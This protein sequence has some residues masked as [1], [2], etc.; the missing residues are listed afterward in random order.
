MTVSVEQEAEELKTALSLKANHSGMK[1]KY[2]DYG[3]NRLMMGVAAHEERSLKGT[4]IQVGCLFC[5]QLH[6]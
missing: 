2:I 1:S 3:S 5:Q 6:V 4:K